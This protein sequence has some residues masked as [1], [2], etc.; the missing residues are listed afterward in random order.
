MK[1]QKL[2][3]VASIGLLLLSGCSKTE[4]D[5]SFD[6]DLYGTYKSELISDTDEILYEDKSSYTFKN[7]ETYSFESYEKIN[8]E[9]K[10]YED[11][12]K[13]K[14]ISKINNDITKIELNSKSKSNPIIFY[15]YKN[16][17]GR[18]YEVKIPK[19]KK[20]N[21]FLQNKDSSVTEGLLFNKNGLYHYCTNYDDCKHDSNSFIKYKREGNYIY[22]DD[23]QGNWTILAYIVE[24]GMFIGE[25]T[26]GKE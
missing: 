21:L 11:S 14:E 2:F 19:T 7:D 9:V 8:E 24:D 10:N 12:G 3:I 6:T 17:I 16:M 20:F 23:S 13:I 18:L 5:I 4:K 15:K 22:R 26:K 1:K 25:Y